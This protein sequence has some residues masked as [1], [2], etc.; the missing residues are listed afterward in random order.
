[1]AWN[2][3]FDRYAAHWAEAQ[4]CA[5]SS[6]DSAQAIAGRDGD[7]GRFAG[8]DRI[9]AHHIELP[10]GARTSLPHAE[11]AEEEFVFVL[12]GTPHLWLDG[13]IHELSP[14]FAVGFPAGTGHAHTFINNSP[15][16]VHLLVAG[17]KSKAENRFIY[18]LNLE[19][20]SQIAEWWDDA[21][22]HKLGPHNGM[23][24]AIKTEE[25]ATSQSPFIV[26]CS[27]SG[28]RKPFHYAGDNETFGEGSR[29]TD[30]LSLKTLGI[31]HEKLPPGRR[32]AFPHAHTHEEEFIYVV[33]G[34]PTLWMDG[35][36]KELGPG[37]FAG[38]P[39]GTGISHVLI[40]DSGKNVVYICIGETREFPGEKIIYPLNEL[41][42]SECTRKGWLWADLPHRFLGAHCG[43]PA[44]EF[45]EHLRFIQC[46]DGDVAR[47]F[48][49]FKQAPG[50]F[51]RVDGCLPTHASAA[52]A[53]VD[54]P[55][56]IGPGYLKETLIVS[57]KGI[58]AGFLDLHINYPEPGL[59]Y[60]GLMLVKDEFVRQGL[61][62]KI[63][64]LCRDY[65]HRAHGVAKV[66]LGVSEANDVSGFWGK[67]GFVPTGHR[68][69]WKGERLTSWVVEFEA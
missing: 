69:E 16:A 39:A 19:R 54:K 61:G 25:L 33:Q 8:F 42:N 30:L 50:Y 45:P 28:G 67:L 13:H 31:W 52:E 34:K 49:I 10:P 62:T 68:Y 40:N 56:K 3:E 32:S 36:T 15:D 24:G 11:S 7:M 18:P 55:A 43:R 21:P 63:Y 14:D 60:L 47:V 5:Q 38:F 20:R 51:S 1:M 64:G 27:A 12:A 57:W 66:R 23:P 44:A 2:K 48:E 53:L 4:R 37:D 6:G 58:D 17:E 29:L 35:F 41:R 59:C 46:G 65:L 22:L 26:D 9:A